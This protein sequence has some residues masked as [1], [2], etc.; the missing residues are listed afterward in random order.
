[1]SV[2][3]QDVADRAGVSLATVGRALNGHQ[4][5]PS[6]AEKISAA[7]AEL[8]Y[9]PN[10]YAVRLNRKGRRRFVVYIPHSHTLFMQI[11]ADQVRE[12]AAEL[13]RSGVEVELIRYDQS[14]CDAFSNELRKADRDFDGIAIMAPSHPAIIE[15]I[16]DLVASGTN[17]VTLVSDQPASRRAGFA[18][19][20]NLAAGRTGGDLLG[21]M[22]GDRNGQVLCVMPSVQVHDH[23]ER[24]AGFQQVLSESYPQLRVVECRCPEVI[25][26]DTD[27]SALPDQ[28]ATF[29]ANALQRARPIAGVFST[30]GQTR[31]I[32]TA[33]ATLPKNPRPV[34]VGYDLTPV[35]R[36]LL[37][38]GV[39]DA[40]IEQSP[41]VQAAR[42]LDMLIEL[43]D[44][45]ILE[46]GAGDINVQIIMRYNL[47]PHR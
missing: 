46:P 5:R 35:S 39:M 1:M 29:I 3:M 4:V 16:N 2:T 20:D 25:G 19:V 22:L 28:S 11:L 44:G 15:A 36:R 18:G 24:A 34:F 41:N 21:R 42:A 26:G 32:S 38:D 27:A 13:A 14:S 9:K 8:D 45:G 43:S 23:I 7:V 12:Q 37:A 40:V 47:P 30:G 31:A 33:L 10:I 6:S 17:V